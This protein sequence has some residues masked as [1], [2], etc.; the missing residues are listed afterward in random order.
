MRDLVNPCLYNGL[1]YGNPNGKYWFMGT[2]EGGAE[3][4][5]NKTLSLEESLR[6]RATFALA[7]DF[8]TVWEDLYHIPMSSFKGPTVW[9]YVAAYLLAFQ[10]VHPGDHKD[11]VREIMQN[12]LGALS[13]EHFLCEL[14]PLP[15]RSAGKIEPFESVWP[16]LKAY[17]A[18]VEQKR[19]EMI[20]QTLLSN[21]EVQVLISYDRK[22]TQRFLAHFDAQILS[23]KDW[24]IEQN[25]RYQLTQL[26]LEK[27][28]TLYFL[29]TPFFGN[30]QISYE[31]VWQSAQRLQDTLTTIAG[32]ER[33]N[34]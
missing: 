30:G 19:F 33:R 28:R 5:R 32:T 26:Q 27:Q 16:S 23:Q 17:H 20:T 9:R 34:I 8:K 12:Q 22:L 3:I 24:C 25:Q 2:E 4:W 29:S 13:G 11:T 1:G 15:K 18:E 31:G 10:Q 6:L 7:M 21:P 14:L